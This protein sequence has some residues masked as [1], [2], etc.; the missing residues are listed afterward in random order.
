MNLPP[1]SLDS[2]YEGAIRATEGVSNPAVGFYKPRE[3]LQLSEATQNLLRQNN[4]I[5]ELLN[6]VNEKL[7][8]LTAQ[9]K[10][11]EGT[12]ASSSG[13]APDTSDLSE[14]VTKLA[15]LTI[16]DKRIY[17]AYKPKIFVRRDPKAIYDAEKA[18]LPQ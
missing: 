3:G 14:L 8:L 4:T 6:R 16:S 13:A 10:R 2:W 1:S 12:H 9:V 5:I 17:P 18:K 7:E 11:L 15:G